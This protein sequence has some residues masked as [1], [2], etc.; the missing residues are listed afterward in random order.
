MNKSIVSISNI[1][2]DRHIL[3]VDPRVGAGISGDAADLDLAGK[4]LP[5]RFRKFDS[6]L[7]I[8]V[9]EQLIL[10]LIS[11]LALRIPLRFGGGRLGIGLDPLHGGGHVI[12][13]GQIRTR[14]NLFRT[15][16][17]HAH[18]PDLAVPDGIGHALHDFR[19]VLKRRNIRPESV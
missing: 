1:Q 18:F 19:F 16:H 5:D 4:I 9:F 10:P 12:Q 7:F 17:D 2:N 6:I 11:R 3:R 15:G 13:S 14:I 8:I